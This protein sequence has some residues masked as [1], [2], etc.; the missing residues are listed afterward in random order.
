MKLSIIMPVY[1][2]EKYIVNCINSILEQTNKDFE[3]IIVNDGSKDNSIEIAKKMTKKFKNI[4]I[5]DKEN[6]GLSDARNF[7]LKYATGQFV[8]FIDSDDCIERDYVEVL[9]DTINKYNADLVLF[10][11]YVDYYTNNILINTNTVIEEYQESNIKEKE[12]IIIH[13]TNC[14]GY[15]WNKVYKRETIISNELEYEKGTSY[16]EDIIFNEKYIAN[17]NKVIVLNKPLYH[18]NQYNNTNTLGN[19]IYDNILELDLRAINSLASIL[20][21]FNYDQ[22]EI[23]NITSNNTISRFSW[24]LKKILL[25]NNQNK[26][27][28]LK[29]YSTYIKNNKAIY[30]KLNLQNKI[31]YY[32]IEKRLYIIN[33]III[34]IKQRLSDVKKLIPN[35]FKDYLKFLFSKSNLYDKNESKVFIILASNY[36]NLGDCLIT[37]AQEC[38]LIDTFKDKKIIKI[39]ANEVYSK[40][41]SIKKSLNNRDVITFIGGGNY[42]DLYKDLEKARG[43]AT[44]Y[45]KK[46]KK[47]YFPQ[48]IVCKNN[49]KDFI[50]KNKKIYDNDKNIIMLRDKESYD[51]LFEYKKSNNYLYPDI[52][53]Y[54]FDKIKDTEKEEYILVCLRNDQEKNKNSNKQEVIDLLE[55]DSYIL[56]D[57]Q[58]KNNNMSDEVLN[59][60]LD[61]LIDKFSKSK[62]VITDRLHGMILAYLTKK[63]FIAIDN[64]N[65]KISRF[66]N[67]WLKNENGIILN[68]TRELTKE[69]ITKQIN[70]TKNNNSKDKEYKE[71]KNNL[72]NFINNVNNK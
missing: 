58:I 21:S 22:Q 66:Y 56:I 25:S 50:N 23:K 24:S 15:A 1:N 14:I 42:G 67:T 64:N 39:N 63:P 35:S 18:Y 68:N 31:F 51:M 54:L 45:L 30:D 37:R 6:G 32:L 69:I 70:S 2:V 27:T 12:K 61:N 47:I 72:I 41:K 17:S 36:G 7:G 5:V 11:Y 34:N 26:K 19:R 46:Y 49:P 10:G 9:L 57:T 48:T 20:N 55:D 4:K 3:L 28:I 53:L 8:T 71:I 40:I 38:F 65:N 33:K 60:E 62:L 43:F 44:R 29:K 16:I 13:D 52:A 59:Y